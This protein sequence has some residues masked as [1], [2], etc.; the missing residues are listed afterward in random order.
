MGIALDILEGFVPMDGLQPG[1]P[2]ETNASGGSQSKTAFR[3]DDM[4]GK[5]MLELA[6]IFKHGHDKYGKDNWRKIPVEDHINHA[7]MHI[8]AYMSGDTQD[9]HI[10]HAH[11]R[12]HFAHALVLEERDD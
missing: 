7:L 3:F 9:D 5:A 4:D 6:K 8:Y 2:T 12:M 10:G 11:A 1:A